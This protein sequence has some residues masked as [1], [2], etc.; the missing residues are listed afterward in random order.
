MTTTGRHIRSPDRVWG[1]R[2]NRLT[3]MGEAS[4]NERRA[5][6]DEQPTSR[7]LKQIN[8]L[9]DDT[10]QA[11]ITN[12]T[13]DELERRIC[14]Q[15]AQ[16]EFY[17]SA[18]ILTRDI[19]G[20]GVTVRT[21][22]GFD[23]T[24][25]RMITDPDSIEMADG[26]LDRVLRTG[27][28]TVNTESADLPNPFHYV[29]EVT[30][31]CGYRST[32]VVPLSYDSTSFGSL[33]VSTTRAEA[34]DEH[35]EDTFGVLGKAI[36]F[37]IHASNTARL[38]SADVVRHLVFE[39]SG[40]DSFLVAITEQLDCSV[41]LEGIVPGDDQLLVY[42]N[43][44]GSSPDVVID[45]IADTPAATD[46]RIIWQDDDWCFLECTV[47]GCSLIS[48]LI[49]YGATIQSGEADSGTGRLVVHLAPDVDVR[50]V[51]A[52][53]KESFP[54]A[55]L[56]EKKT[57]ED[58]V[59]SDVYTR[60]TLSDRLTSKQRSVLRAAFLGG[61]YD[62]PRGTTAQELADSLGIASSTFH[63]HLQAAQRKLLEALFEE[64]VV[65]SG[66][67]SPTGSG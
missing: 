55:R 10:V 12:S 5:N 41:S 17:S 29:R 2:P 48:S 9:L 54:H 42:L 19:D 16:S 66:F 4:G 43:V 7:V 64:P 1:T 30:L 61:Y 24:F 25:I 47:V 51:V 6:G 11:L 60:Q 18:G 56:R 50:A 52:T 15:L 58:P 38:V 53:I 8:Q 22:V 57:V 63:Q 59:R 26:T 62:H 27:P 40:S 3:A 44:E 49:E 23:E 33:L 28:T 45:A 67:T 14:E 20:T 21:S 34:F 36:G 37:A 31:T 65:S 32:I 13:R 35:L 46:P 39:I